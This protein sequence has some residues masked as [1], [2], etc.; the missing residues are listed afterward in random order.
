MANK[1]LTFDLFGVDK[2]ASK[3]IAG[4]GRAGEGMGRALSSGAFIAGAALA[5]AAVAATAFAVDSIKAFAEA[6]QAQ[7]RLAFAVQK[8]PSL[9]GAN[10][11]AIQA[12]NTAL[13]ART[14]FEDDAIA[15]AQGALAMYDLTAAQLS[16][17][18]PLMLDYAAATGKSAGDAAEDFGKAILGQ[19]RALKAIGLDFQDA[20][21]PVSNYT[22]LVA[23]LR[24]QVQGFA[25]KDALTVAGR[26]DMINNQFGD[27]QEKLGSAFAPALNVAADVVE[28]TLIPALDGVIDRVGPQLQAGFAAL[29]P[30]VEDAVDETMPALERLLEGIPDVIGLLAESTAGDFGSGGIF[31]PEVGENLED[32]G[33]YLEEFYRKGVPLPETLDGIHNFFNGIRDG[34]TAADREIL[35]E[36]ES[37]KAHWSDMVFDM[38]QAVIDANMATEGWQFAQGFA[39]GI[40]S[41]SE[42]A[43]LAAERMALAAR[44]KVVNTMQ[45]E[46]PS[47]VM[48][49]LGAY[50]PQGLALGIEDDMWRVG[51]AFDRMG[52]VATGRV[53]GSSSAVGFGGGGTVINVRGS[54]LTDRRQLAKLQRDTTRDARRQ[55][56][57]VRG[58]YGTA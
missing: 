41:N 33:E 52:S 57:S 46:S 6:E 44:D 31:D 18:T 42:A 51:A 22:A 50:I 58:A 26:L 15:A 35:A 8:Y 49:D 28:S 10:I 27:V 29:A 45:I 43:V 48:R 54:V 5:A 2:T 24:T 13:Q 19:G 34:L 36:S 7:N 37:L 53:S 14:R 16:E 1:S 38:R 21:D 56:L 32:F 12:E 30:A 11:A 4:V 23:G 9:A 20:G 17:L 55:G 39:D 47:K 40:T 3:A 25:E